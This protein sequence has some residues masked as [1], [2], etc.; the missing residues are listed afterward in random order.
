M[1]NTKLGQQH[2]VNVAINLIANTKNKNSGTGNTTTDSYVRSEASSLYNAI[3]RRHTNR[4]PYEKN[5]PMTQDILESLRKL[6]IAKYLSKRYIISF[7][8][9]S[10]NAFLALLYASSV[11]NNL[12]LET[13]H[14]AKLPRLLTT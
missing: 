1:Q 6:V 3:P 7:F 14:I 5:R 11:M 2:K 10:I 9:C 4:G 12:I 8:C 13:N